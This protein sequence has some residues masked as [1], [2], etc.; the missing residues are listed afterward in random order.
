MFIP[1][2]SGPLGAGITSPGSGL[3]VM[4]MHTGVSCCLL[5]ANQETTVQTKLFKLIEMLFVFLLTLYV[6]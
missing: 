6:L 4:P 3:S 5:C 2:G 1:Q